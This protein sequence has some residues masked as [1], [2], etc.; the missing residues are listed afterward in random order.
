MENAVG[1]DEIGTHPGSGVMANNVTNSAG[2]SQVG[3][4]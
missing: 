1:N 3:L 2:L 4:P